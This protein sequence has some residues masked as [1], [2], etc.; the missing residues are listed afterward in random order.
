MKVNYQSNQT[1]QFN[2]MSKNQIEEIASTA[3]DILER[4][5]V[6]VNDPEILSL[7]KDAGCIVKG[8]RAFIPSFLVNECLALAP[9]KITMSDRNGIRAMVLEK[10]RIYFGTGSDC[11]FILDSFT[12]ERRKWLQKDIE[13]GAK[14]VDYL[15][16]MDFHMS[17]GLTSD[18]PS[19]TYDRYQFLS[20]TKNTRKPLILTT[21][22]G[23]GLED[24]Y[25]ISCILTEGE[26][27]F[28]LRPFFALYAEPITPLTHAKEA[29]DTVGKRA[30][31]ARYP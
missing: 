27:N 28:K 10:D 17:V 7:L 6:D 24:I 3:Y 16:N 22:D 11:V 19:M 12:G 8:I 9:K 15:P 26:D 31:Q 2:V 25:N 21:V 23:K 20:M 13:N 5:G 29:L 4:V 1:L 30:G 18:V 14:I